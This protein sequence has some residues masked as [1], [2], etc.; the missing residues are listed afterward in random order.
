M[1]PTDAILQELFRKHKIALDSSDPVLML[2][3]LLQRFLEQLLEQQ[4]S[5]AEEFAAKL[6][7]E[8]QAWDARLRERALHVIDTALDKARQQAGA[9]YEEKC[10]RF[11]ET[12]TRALDNALVTRIER[13]EKDAQWA[14]RMAVANM[15]AG[16]FLGLAIVLWYLVK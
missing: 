8:L 4:A 6:D 1:E 12:M 9:Q 11:G 5:Q 10:A 13:L 7:N 2:H 15:I 14:W 3:T 16:G